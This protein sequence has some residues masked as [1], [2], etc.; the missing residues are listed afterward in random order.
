MTFAAPWGR[1]LKVMSMIGG[2]VIG[3]PIVVQS[4]EGRWV[5]PVLMASLLTVIALYCVRGYELEPGM[6]L[7]RRLLW[8]TRWP[9]DETAHATVRP[10]AMRGSWR[11]W[12]NG[13]LFAITGRFSGSGLGGYQAFVTDPSRTVIITTRKGIVVVSPDRPDA[14]VD[15]LALHARRSA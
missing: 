1:E 13:G 11:M 10:H 14:F 2:G 7:V 4:L 5:V 3:V 12:G 15:A 8:Y 9:L 6:L